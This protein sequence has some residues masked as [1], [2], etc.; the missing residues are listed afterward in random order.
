MTTGN[1]SAIAKLGEFV[2]HSHGMTTSSTGPT[3]SIIMKQLSDEY[4]FEV[5]AFVLA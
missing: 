5:N 2:S 3:P 4:G 1:H